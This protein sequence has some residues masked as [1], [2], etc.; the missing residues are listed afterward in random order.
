[1][2]KFKKR[3]YYKPKN[4]PFSPP[5]FCHPKYIKDPK[6]VKQEDCIY[7]LWFEYLRRSSKYFA[8][9]KNGGKGMEE[10]YADFGDVFKD[11]FDEWFSGEVSGVVRGEYLFAYPHVTALREITSDEQF[12][13]VDLQEYFVFA[14]D[15]F[16]D[17]KK[18]LE[19]LKNIW[20]SKVTTNKVGFKRARYLPR[21]NTHNINSLKEYLK[22]YD[23]KLLGLKHWECV[24]KARNLKFDEVVKDDR[25]YFNIIASKALKKAKKLIALTEQGQFI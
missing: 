12:R 7:Y 6:L 11:T 19:T 20:K 23:A 24:A 21:S 2:Y 16:A 18:T 4:F 8:A 15:K 22:I 13:V 3:V 14:I 17:K 9:C 1:M 25:E 5:Y 10:L